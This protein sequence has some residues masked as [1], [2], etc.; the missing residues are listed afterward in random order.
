MTP[1]H[2][3]ELHRLIEALQD[4]KPSMRSEWLAQNVPHDS[5]FRAQL[6]KQL[7]PAA[8]AA[9][10][11]VGFS[12]PPPDEDALP[13][14][15]ARPPYV[16][17]GYASL[18]LKPSRILPDELLGQEHEASYRAR[19]EAYKEKL[20][21]AGSCPD[22]DTPLFWTLVQQSSGGM[23]SIILP[24]GG[25]ALPVF[26]SPLLA[27]DYYDVHLRSQ[28]LNPAACSA[29]QLLH[30]YRASE[31]TAVAH[32]VLDRCPR[33]DIVTLHRIESVR[34]P[35]QLIGMWAFSKAAQRARLELYMAY[36]HE[37]LRVDRERAKDVALAIVGH[38][39]A[40]DPRTHLLLG[41]I[42]IQHGDHKLLEEAQAFLR[43]LKYEHWENELRRQ[44]ELHVSKHTTSLASPA[45]EH[46]HSTPSVA[47][48]P[49]TSATRVPSRETVD[50]PTLTDS[51]GEPI[52]PREFNSLYSVGELID[53]VFRV[54]EVRRGGMGVVYI[55]ERE[56]HDVDRGG[57]GF[58]HSLEGETAGDEAGRLR[59][60]RWFAIKMMGSG[61]HHIPEVQL[62]ERECLVWSTLLPHPNIVRAL[63]AGRIDAQNPFVLLEFVSGGNLR[64]RIRAG[65][66][67]AASLQIA[68][69]VCRG[70][71]FLKDSAGIVHRDIKPENILLTEGGVAKVTDFG[72]VRVPSEEPVASGQFVRDDGIMDVNAETQGLLAGSLPYMAPEQFLGHVADT[73]SDVYS[74]GVV[75]YE[76]LSTRRP[77]E[78]SDFRAYRERH[79]N[80]APPPLPD[81]RVS[82]ELGS[83]VLKCL[84][85]QPDDRFRDFAELASRLADLCRQRGLAS[86]VPESLTD[87]D[88]HSTM[89]SADWEGRALALLT[90]GEALNSR[91]APESGRPYLEQAYLSFRRAGEIDGGRPSLVVPKGRVLSLLG[92][93]EQAERH[94]REQLGK[95]PTSTLQAIG[96][97]R[98]LV[99]LGRIDEAA[100]VLAEATRRSPQDAELQLEIFRFRLKHR[101]EA[102]IHEAAR[103]F[104]LAEPSPLP[105]KANTH[106]WHR[107]FR[108]RREPVSPILAL[109]SGNRLEEP[110]A[111][112]TLVWRELQE[113]L[114][115]G[116]PG[117]VPES[118]VG[119]RLVWRNS[120]GDIL[121]TY[122]VTEASHVIT[123]PSDQISLQRWA[124]EIATSRGAGLLEARVVPGGSGPGVAF[125]YKQFLNE[126]Y[127]FTG[128]LILHGT[129]M[130]WW[131]IVAREGGTAIGQRESTIT[132]E[133]LN[134]GELTVSEYE[135]EWARD[136]YDR[137]HRGVERE[138]LRTMSDDERYDERFPFHPL[139]RV[140]RVMAVLESNSWARP[141]VRP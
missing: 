102:E 94:F 136:P 105:S 120:V 39:T 134:A 92:R 34:A 25:F 2:D 76:M 112:D 78:A 57:L 53:S 108:R 125:V 28:S 44:A 24:G 15:I 74:F 52:P 32:A 116:L 17:P 113:S 77:F 20:L 6:L 63:T 40:E 43:F 16:L 82:S 4:L 33:C 10:A 88:L 55:V 58:V 133:L 79:L 49:Q 114:R 87:D 100:E 69:H 138:A 91:N 22:D 111:R 131:V 30:V 83:V 19:I 64:D 81:A 68:L 8:S 104:S 71:Q 3:S 128:F 48:S 103:V 98:S 27:A 99:G 96:L 126:A 14:L 75:L 1:F 12:I 35:K 65:I 124:R 54:K 31:R 45:T 129:P 115:L 26:S 137:S 61:L 127:T 84:A 21:E 73:R 107:I 51:R 7:A 123:D 106:W 109:T 139:S 11:D 135:R 23:A 9:A 13:E 97:S 46:D 18:R 80:D 85:K 89:T 132:A 141:R 93:H 119:E 62:F 130:F 122:R 101:G 50:R 66:D 29:A 41:F 56:R 90:I 60:R 72:L 37:S 95:E 38:V 47:A 117:W 42:A 121:V 86:I 67:V 140:R 110:A 70:M 5:A 36:A 59:D 118:S